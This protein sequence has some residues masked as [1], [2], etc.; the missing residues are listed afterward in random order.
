MSNTWVPSDENEKSSP[1]FDLF[2]PNTEDNLQEVLAKG[3]YKWTNKYT[4]VFALALLV[5]TSTSAG[6]WYGHRSASSGTGISGLA[7]AAGFAR[8]GRNGGFG[9]ASASPTGGGAAAFAGGGFGGG[10]GTPGVVASVKGKSVTVTLDTDP[11]TPLKA[12]DSVSVRNSGGGQAPAGVAPQTS[13]SSSSS[14]NSSGAPQTPGASVPSGAP[15]AGNGAGRGGGV[16]GVGGI[17]SNPAFVAC[18]KKEGVT[19]AAGQGFDRTDPKVAAAL[20]TCFASVGGGFGGGTRPPGG[21]APAASAT[22]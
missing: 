1:E 13:S 22:P 17:A 6:I 15:Q 20:Q 18:L 12:G 7:S 2:A 5:V 11:A 21:P 16:G 8:A 10:R 4:A 14:S 19:I 9:G 3:S